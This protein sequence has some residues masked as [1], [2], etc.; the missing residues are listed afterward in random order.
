MSN[1]FK[2]L[3]DPAGGLVGPPALTQ[4]LMSAWRGFRKTRTVG[5]R[6]AWTSLRRSRHRY[7]SA[8]PTEPGWPLDARAVLEQLGGGRQWRILYVPYPAGVV[9]P[10][11]MSTILCGS[12]PLD[13]R[14]NALELLAEITHPTG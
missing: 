6:E 4:A 14:A 5:I 8:H 2:G 3:R 1:A 7:E 10:V 9:F 12:V 13:R 11:G